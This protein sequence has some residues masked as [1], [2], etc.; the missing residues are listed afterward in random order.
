M[1]Q[2]SREAIVLCMAD[3]K[4]VKYLKRANAMRCCLFL[5]MSHRQAG[6]LVGWLGGWVVL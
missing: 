6:G 1:L 2:E 5:L 4:H 3:G